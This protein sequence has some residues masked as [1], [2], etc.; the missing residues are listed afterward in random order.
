MNLHFKRK[1]SLAAF[2]YDSPIKFMHQFNVNKFMHNKIIWCSS[3][4]WSNLM[5]T[6]FTLEQIANN[7]HQISNVSQALNGI[8]SLL[9]LIILFLIANK[10]QFSTSKI[11]INC[12]IFACIFYANL[13]RH[14]VSS[15][16]TLFSISFFSLIS[17]NLRLWNST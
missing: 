6:I 15:I 13:V 7:L 4:I 9:D 8:K 10:K 17:F 5:L 16:V 14:L 12:S 11:I 2:D 1:F 3:F